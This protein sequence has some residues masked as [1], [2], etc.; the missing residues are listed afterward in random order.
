MT[1]GVGRERDHTNA[2][3]AAIVAGRRRRRSRAGDRG[4]GGRTRRRPRATTGPRRR[5]GGAGPGCSRPAGGA[6][7]ARSRSG[8]SARDLPTARSPP[9]PGSAG[10]SST[11][12]GPCTC[13]WSRTTAPSCADYPVVRS[14]V[15]DAA[16]HRHVLGV[17][18]VPLHGRRR[19]PDPD[20]VHG[21]VR[22]GEAAARRSASTTSRPSGARPSSRSKSLG[23]PASH[24]C[25]R[26]SE[27]TPSSCGT[28]RPSARSWSR[29]RLHRP[30]AR[31]SRPGRHPRGDASGTRPGRGWM[32]L[33]VATSPC[34][35]GVR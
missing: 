19:Q 9:A 8:R 35:P 15:P 11:T 27:E 3:R 4:A 22:G 16:G 24:G 14:Q 34:S 20:G 7:D 26:Q 18:E 29:H 31:V 23:Q 33:S 28:G 5:P 13:G 17:L 25:V 12:W 6:A 2:S 21:A 1:S 32:R 30:G 10:G